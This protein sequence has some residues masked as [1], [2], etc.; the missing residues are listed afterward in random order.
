MLTDKQVLKLL[1]RWGEKAET[2]SCLAE[3][4]VYD[5]LSSWQCYILALNPNDADMIYCIISGGKNIKPE[6]C[7]WSL[8]ELCMLYNSEGESPIVDHEYKPKLAAEIFKQLN[9]GKYDPD[10]N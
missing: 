6:A 2:L 9:Q 1:T 3:V 10:R 4:R 5:P 7:E 8:Y